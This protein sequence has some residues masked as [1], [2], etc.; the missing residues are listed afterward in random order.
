MTKDQRENIEHELNRLQKLS[1][2]W[3]A[4][5]DK[6]YEEHDDQRRDKFETKLIIVE[7]RINGMRD[8]LLRLGYN[9]IHPMNGHERDY[10]RYIVV[11]RN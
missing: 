10:S 7:E 11:E 6:A 4:K 3:E 2:M 1:D 9:A 8:V 5:A